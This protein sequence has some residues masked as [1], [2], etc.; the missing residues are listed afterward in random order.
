MN[1]FVYNKDYIRELLSQF[2]QNEVFICENFFNFDMCK[3]NSKKYD[4]YIIPLCFGF[5]HCDL[6]IMY[7]FCNLFFNKLPQFKGNESKHIVF[8]CNDYHEEPFIFQNL[9]LFKFSSHINGM[10]LPIHYRT[11]MKTLPT[12]ENYDVS[13]VGNVNSNKTRACL[14]KSLMNSGLNYFFKATKDNFFMV[15]ADKKEEMILEFEQI[16]NQSKFILCPRGGG[17]NSMRFFETMSIG[18]IPILISDFAK[19]PLEKEID[20]SKFVVRVP[21]NKIKNIKEYIDDFMFK[22]DIKQASVLS[23]SMWLNYFSPDKIDYFLEKS[24]SNN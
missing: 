17:L 1:F 23:R 8:I 10:S 20:Y 24:I 4:Y 3:S 9:I 2:S 11:S 21:E 5:T 12:K 13:F 16:S 19:L 15:N 14:K 7:K 18:K 22:V 6:N